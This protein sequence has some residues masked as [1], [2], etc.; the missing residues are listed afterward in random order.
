MPEGTVYVNTY[1]RQ[2]GSIFVQRLPEFSDHLVV[3]PTSIA[4]GENVAEGTLTDDY[5]NYVSE[6]Y[7]ISIDGTIVKR[8]FGTDV[9]SWHAQEPLSEGDHVITVRVQG[10]YGFWSQPSEITITVSGRQNTAA[11]Q[12]VFGVDAALT[13]EANLP[14]DEIRW[15]RDGKLIGTSSGNDQN[16][17]V[18]VDRHVLGSHSY[19]TRPRIKKR[20]I[21]R[22][23]T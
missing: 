22:R 6:G 2:V 9:Y 21:F 20:R 1:D 16:Q 15:Y 8:A 13:T 3:T 19:F 18:F 23:S 4:L 14:G 7:E 12:G 5:L 11:L 10:Q 17:A